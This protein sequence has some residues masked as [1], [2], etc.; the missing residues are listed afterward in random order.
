MIRLF[1]GK[2]LAVRAICFD[3]AGRIFLVRHTYTHGWHLPGGGVANGLSA[4]EA[5]EKELRE[6]GNLVMV[7]APHLHQLFFNKSASSREHIALYTVI[8]RQ[9]SELKPTME[10][11]EGKFFP[12]YALPRDIDLPT[13]RRIEELAVGAV[14]GIVW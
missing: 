10:I 4:H 5:L 12:P 13:A 7:S 9:V 3:E 6:E 8:V 1:S 11:V 14:V 2:V